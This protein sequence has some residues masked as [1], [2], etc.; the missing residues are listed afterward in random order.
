MDALAKE[1]LDV[2]DNNGCV[3]D[4]VDLNAGKA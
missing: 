2:G 4:G 3:I 1:V